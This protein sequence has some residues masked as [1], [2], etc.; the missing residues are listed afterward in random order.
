MHAVLGVEQQRRA[1]PLLDQ[2]LEDGHRVA[3]LS[4]RYG[5]HRRGQLLVVARKHH[6]LRPWAVVV[7][8]LERDE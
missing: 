2:D 8:E 4:S 7:E 6:A 3:A 1:A 5:D